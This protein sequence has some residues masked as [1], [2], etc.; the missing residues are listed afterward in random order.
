MVQLHCTSP[1]KEQDEADKNFLTVLRDQLSRCN[2]NKKTVLPHISYLMCSSLLLLTTS[3]QLVASFSQ[4]HKK[5]LMD[6]VILEMHGLCHQLPIVGKMQQNPLS[7]ENLRNWCHTFPIVWVLFSHP[8]PI[9]WH[10]SAYGKCIGFSINFPERGKIQQNSL[11][12]EK[13]GNWYSY[14]S[15]S[16]DGFSHQISILLYT[17]SYGKCMGFLISFSQH[18]NGSKTHLMG[19]D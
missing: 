17:S 12:E 19:K 7:S 14:F 11:H 4:Y 5:T 9:L 10:T 18:G 15:H 6:P 8:I 2:Q 16:M 3:S 1:A 13:L